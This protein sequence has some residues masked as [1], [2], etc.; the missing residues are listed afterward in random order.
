MRLQYSKVKEVIEVTFTKDLE[1]GYLHCGRR[2]GQQAEE[3]RGCVT[4]RDVMDA[5]CMRDRSRYGAASGA[6][7]QP[8]PLPVSVPYI[9]LF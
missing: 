1:P 5:P 3:G 4:K 7:M 9:L 2:R 6:C 8:L